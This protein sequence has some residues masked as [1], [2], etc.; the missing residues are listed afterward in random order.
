MR[1]QTQALPTKQILQDS[2]VVQQEIAELKS[3]VDSLL[4]GGFRI[5][6]TGGGALSRTIDGH[7]G[8][9]A[10]TYQTPTDVEKYQQQ[11]PFCPLETAIA[12]VNSQTWFIKV[13]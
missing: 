9:S 8:R 2:K 7:T 6:T 4:K 13:M 5:C 10:I 1:Q 11:N 3:F 12:E